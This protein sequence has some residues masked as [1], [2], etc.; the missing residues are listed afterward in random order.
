MSRRPPRRD[1]MSMAGSFAVHGLAFFA[2]WWSATSNPPP[3]NFV[4][5][6]IDI[7]SPPPAVHAAKETVTKKKLVVERPNP[8][9]EPKKKAPAPV[10]Q[11]KKKAP[12]KSTAKKSTPE[13]TPTAKAAKKNE[14]ATTTEKVAPK[15]KSAESGEGLRVK[16]EGLRRDYPAYYAD[17]IRQMARCF[18]W[19]KGGDW[20]TVIYFVI[21]KDGSVKDIKV[22]QPSGNPVFDIQAMGAA[23][24]AGQGRLDSL[25]KD[26]PFDK[27]PVRF[28]IKPSG[29]VGGNPPNAEE[30]PENR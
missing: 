3:T 8:Q 2:A 4:T 17:I 29:G 16:M 9:P 25:P 26:L 15:K 21:Q 1:P 10:T 11:P 28:R 18:R 5:Y 12:A 14:K 27:L 24:C 20:S 23:E 30:E 22:V 13:A 7:V 19:D 6:K